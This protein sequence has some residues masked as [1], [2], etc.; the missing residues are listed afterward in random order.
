MKYHKLFSPITLRG[1][2]FPNRIMRTSM[3]SGLATEDGAVTDVLK[4]RYQREAKGG[5]GSFVVEAAVVLPSRSSYNLR[6][7]DDSFV[8]IDLDEAATAGGGAVSDGEVANVDI[9]CIN[10]EDG[11]CVVSVYCGD[12]AVFAEEIQGLV[13]GEC[14]LISAGVDDDSVAIRCVVDGVL[15]VLEGFVWSDIKGWWGVCLTYWHL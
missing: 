5:V 8:D 11:G 10:S 14:F 4:E 13:N 1:V 2:T 9:V 15:D 6:I 3:V 7:S 12:S